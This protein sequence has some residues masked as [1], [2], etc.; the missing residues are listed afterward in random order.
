MTQETIAAGIRRLLETESRAKLRVII[1]ALNESVTI[2]G[3]IEGIPCDISGIHETVVL[4]I[5]DGATDDTASPT[6]A[7]FKYNLMDIQAALGIHQL[8]RVGAT[9]A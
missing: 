4:V 8:A 6:E 5:D 2:Q 3:L 7:G 1:P 9:S